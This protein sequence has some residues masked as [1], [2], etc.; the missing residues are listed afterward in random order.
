MIFLIPAFQGARIIGMGHW[1]L[2]YGFFTVF[3]V[4]DP[5]TVLILLLFLLTGS[6]NKLPVAIKIKTGLMDSP[7]IMSEYTEQH[8]QGM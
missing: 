3:T 8:Y 5:K 7:E 1:H 2:V 6:I 4:C